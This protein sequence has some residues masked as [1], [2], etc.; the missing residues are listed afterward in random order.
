MFGFGAEYRVTGNVALGLEVMNYG[1]R[2]SEK[3]TLGLGQIEA[4]VR[5]SF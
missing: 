3:G 1:R 2:K 4:S 5:Y